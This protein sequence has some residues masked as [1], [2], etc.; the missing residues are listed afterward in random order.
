MTSASGE[1][2]SSFISTSELESKLQTLRE[3]SNKLSQELTQRL[4]TSESGQNLMQIGPSLSTLPPDLHSLITYIQPLLNDVEEYV[5]ANSVELNRLQ[6]YQL[7]I[8][9][10]STRAQHARQCASIYEDLCAGERDVQRDLALLK[11][12]STVAAGDGPFDDITKEDYSSKSLDGYLVFSPS[13]W[14]SLY[15]FFTSFTSS[16]IPIIIIRFG[17]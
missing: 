7:D 8:E 1:G 2:L 9:A 4:A 10:C 11:N 6:Q 17:R 3:Q 13:Y 15:L 14:L 5:E 12:S 16:S